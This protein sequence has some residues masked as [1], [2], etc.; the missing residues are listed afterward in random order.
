MPQ[1]PGKPRTTIGWLGLVVGP[2]VWMILTMG[3]RLGWQIDPAR[4]GLND[5]AGITAWMALWWMTEAVPVAVTGLLPLVLFPALEIAP[6]REVAA[7]YG[8]RL[9][10]LFLGGFLIA[11][12]IQASGLHRRIA[13]AIVSAVGGGASRLVLGM[14]LATG[15]LSMWMSNTAT[16]I[17]MLPIAM[18]LLA[19]VDAQ[20][21]DPRWKYN[22]GVALMLGVGYAASL[23][24]LATLIGTPTNVLFKQLYTDSYQGRAPDVTFGGW[25]MMAGP[26][27]LTLLL[28]CWG[29]LAH[30]LFPVGQGDFGGQQLIAQQRRDLGRMTTA[31]RRSGVIFLVTALLWVFREPIRGWGWAPLLGLGARASGGELIDDSSIA[32]AMAALCFIVPR[33]TWRGPPLLTWK[34]TI[35]VPWGVLLLFGGG[36]ALAEGMRH[37]GFDEY[38][39][40]VLGKGLV[41]YSPPV[42]ATIVAFTVTMLSELTSNIAC[43]N[44]TLPVMA[45]LARAMDC[46]PRLLMLPTAL[47]ASC[48]FM[49]PVATAPNAIVYGTGRLTAGEMARAGWLLDLLCVAVIVL[50]VF[51]LGIPVFNISLEG[52]P[53]WA[54]AGQP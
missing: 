5:M 45:G 13:L 33:D 24:G 37:T 47:A 7:A 53:E 18:S 17:L 21:T 25:M 3:S 9:L 43:V 32:I 40:Q 8:N 29:L 6:A 30:L 12:T 26:V 20:T 39:G 14:I 1:A 48:G 22:F 10:F 2:A 15:L 46:D 38:L 41:G 51:L 28:A 36:L 54:S 11:L 31:E 35:E 23:G 19:H 34:S 4:P 42:I 27:S 50:G 52:L 16:T 44:I 49:L